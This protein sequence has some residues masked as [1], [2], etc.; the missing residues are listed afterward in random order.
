MNFRLIVGTFVAMLAFAGNSVL[1]RLALEQ[2]S[3]DPASFTSVRLFSGALM[4]SILLISIPKLMVQKTAFADNRTDSSALN[5]AHELDPAELSVN[6][7]V[8]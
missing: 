5:I 8:R 3:I 1:C 2:D 7:K 4:L 6:E